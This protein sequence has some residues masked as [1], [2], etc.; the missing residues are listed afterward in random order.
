MLQQLDRNR[1]SPQKA[2]NTEEGREKACPIRP[3]GSPENIMLGCI[4]AKHIAW[5]DV[6]LV[7]SFVQP[8]RVAC[9]MAGHLILKTCPSVRTR[10]RRKMSGDI[11]LRIVRPGIIKIEEELDGK[12]YGINR[13]QKRIERDI[14]CSLYHF[15][16]LEGRKLGIN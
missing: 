2:V 7:K 8:E 14:Y 6:F 15:R 5:R 11:I 13:Y 16:L 1:R 9:G 3:N 12:K 4:H 10:Q